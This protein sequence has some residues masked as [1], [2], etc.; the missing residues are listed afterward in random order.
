MRQAWDESATTK[1]KRPGHPRYRAFVVKRDG[2]PDLTSLNLPNR[3]RKKLD[4]LAFAALRSVHGSIVSPIAKFSRLSFGQKSSKFTG[5]PSPKIS[6]YGSNRSGDRPVR[7]RVRTAKP[8][9]I[10]VFEV[11]QVKALGMRRTV[12]SWQQIEDTQSI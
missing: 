4:R 2:A 8:G 11:N 5:V 1:T 10:E 12:F 6:F 3:F 7:Q 9:E